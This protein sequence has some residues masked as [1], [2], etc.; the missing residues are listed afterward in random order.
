MRISFSNRIQD[1]PVKP[2]GARMKYTGGSY[3]CPN[4]AV[5]Q[6]T[7]IF[8]I[9]TSFSSQI[10]CHVSLGCFFWYWTIPYSSLRDTSRQ[11]W[12]LPADLW[13]WYSNPVSL[14]SFLFSFWTWVRRIVL[15]L[16]W[17]SLSIDPWLDYRGS[18]NKE[19]SHPRAHSPSRCRV[20][21]A[22]PSFSY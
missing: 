9:V 6:R 16:L 3:V 14:V 4:L 13:T 10:H 2:S 11:R 21:L 1:K 22:H 7:K 5:R 17:W 12:H 20:S 8:L 18:W 15:A 19:L